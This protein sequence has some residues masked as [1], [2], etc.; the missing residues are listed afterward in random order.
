MD[1][2]KSMEVIKMIIKNENKFN[3]NGVVRMPMFERVEPSHESMGS[4]TNVNPA[5]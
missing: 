5:P 4:L 2:I 3:S 1:L